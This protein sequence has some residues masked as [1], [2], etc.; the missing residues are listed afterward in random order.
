M[1]YNSVFDDNIQ[2]IWINGNNA[3]IFVSFSDD[4]W[5]CLSQYYGE[6]IR[7]NRWL[8]EIEW[9]FIRRLYKLFHNND[10]IGP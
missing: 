1:T 3:K 9:F 5:L 2:R 8:H 7:G 4:V 6:I 10:Q